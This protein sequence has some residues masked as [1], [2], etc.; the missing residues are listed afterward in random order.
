M[1][2]VT[3]HMP[4]TQHQRTHVHWDAQ[5]HT[6]GEDEE[7]VA[8]LVHVHVA[9][10]CIDTRCRVLGVHRRALNALLDAARA[11]G[12]T[13]VEMLQR[14]HPQGEDASDVSGG[15]DYEEGDQQEVQQVSGWERVIDEGNERWRWTCP[16]LP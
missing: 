10:E 8:L 1:P 3:S 12:A 9:T 2:L 14:P 16:H 15:Y 13:S 4:R 11:A 7:L 5:V 6:V